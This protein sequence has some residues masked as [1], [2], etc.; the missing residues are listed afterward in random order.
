MRAQAL[1]VPDERK[2]HTI[3]IPRS[4][5][6]AMALGALVPVIFWTEI[7]PQLTAYL[8]GCAILFIAGLYDDFR[9]GLNVAAKFM[10][11]VAAALVLVF[12]GGVMIRDLGNI[13][14]G[15]MGL[16]YW[17]AAIVT[18]VVVVGVTNA[19]NLADGL[20][21]L[22]GGISLLIFLFISFLAYSMENINIAVGGIE[23]FR[24]PV[25]L[26]AI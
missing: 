22:A 2:V 17:S 12:Y 15:D 3:P 24:S 7:T 6:V 4:G 1:D 9:G 26:F 20:D 14:P 16:P 11:Q 25:W 13:L 23:S 19:I 8:I 18:V 21:G 5:G 10:A